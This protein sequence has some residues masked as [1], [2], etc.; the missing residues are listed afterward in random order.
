[1]LFC[2]EIITTLIRQQPASNLPVSGA[3]AAVDTHV[4]LSSTAAF[5]SRHLRTTAS[6]LS[7]SLLVIMAEQQE[8]PVRLGVKVHPPTILVEYLKYPTECVPQPQARKSP[9]EFLRHASAS[10]LRRKIVRLHNLDSSKVAASHYAAV[11]Q[12]CCCSYCASAIHT[13]EGER[14]YQGTGTG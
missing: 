3:R 4:S 1:M 9:D 2:G 11:L 8:G 14:C 6:S 10:K 5:C 13:S 7:N 12:Q